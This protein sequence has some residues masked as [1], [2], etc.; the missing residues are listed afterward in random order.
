L[1]ENVR[2]LSMQVEALEK[3][4]YNQDAL[5]NQERTL[6]EQ[7]REELDEL[8]NT[9]GNLEIQNTKLTTELTNTKS[10][11]EQEKRKP[12]SSVSNEVLLLIHLNVLTLLKQVK[13]LE[14]RA[15][16]AEATAADYEAKIAR[17]VAAVKTERAQLR[18]KVQAAE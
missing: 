7:L 4:L 9:L 8:N 14:E 18:D 15:I 3:E 13:Q 5:R 1:E 12:S 11:L 10:I 17:L 6:N 2:Q 16:K